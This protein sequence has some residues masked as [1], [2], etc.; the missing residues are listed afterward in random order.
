[1]KIGIGLVIGDVPKS[2]KN[3]F[4][5]NYGNMSINIADILFVI[6]NTKDGIK[7]II[8][9]WKFQT[10]SY[11]KNEDNSRNMSRDYQ[12]ILNMARFYNCDWLFLLDIDE[13]LTGI[14]KEDVIEAIQNNPVYESFGFTLYEMVNDFKHYIPLS[15]KQDFRVCHKLFKTSPHL[16]FNIYDKHGQCMPHNCPAG[17]ILKS[18][19]LHFG[20]FNKELRDFKKKQYSSYVSDN[21]KD[22]EELEAIW[23]KKNFEVK[24]IEL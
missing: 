10:I 19:L 1:M 14:I 5:E 3:M 21:N 20:H 4:F 18:K 13:V 16:F 17:P 22:K 23:F 9:T 2:V 6:D 11:I 15:K 12:K 7:D 24:E 8:K